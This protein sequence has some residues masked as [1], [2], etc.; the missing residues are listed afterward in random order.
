[1]FKFFTSDLRRNLI[2]ILCL[3][4]GLAVGFLLVAKIYFEQSYDSFFP[5]LDRIYRLTESVVQNGE[6]RE[7][8][9]T[10]GGSASELQRNISQIDKATR[11]TNLTGE[12]VM[13]LDD[14]RKFDVPCVTLADSCL[15]DVLKTPV[16]EGNPHEVLAVEDRLMI[17]RSLAE[18]IGGDV[19]GQRMS[20]VEWGDTYKATIGGVYEDYPLN[21]TIDNAVYI[22][23]PTIGK[24]M[25]DGSENLLGNDRYTSYVLL[26]EGADPEEVNRMMVEHLKTVI[27]EEEAFT[28]LDFRMWVR[29]MAGA[30]ARQDGVR[31][32][33]WMLGMLAL[34]ML[35]CAGLN[36]LLIV[37]G[38]LAARG[39][40]M[41]IRKCFGTG[42]KS[43][44][45]M[46]MGESLFFLIVSLGLAVLLAF[47]FS[48]LCKE[49][50][51]YSP[52]ELFSTGKVWLVEGLVCLGL[53]IITGIIPSIIYSRTPVAHAF[54]PAT[55]G[56]KIWKLALL[57]L[58]FLATGMIMC[59]LV[60]IGRQYHMIG[61][62]D[63]G[64]D[65]EDIGVFYRYP[66]TREKTYTVM[67][68]LR[69]L[70]FVESVASSDTDPTAWPSGNNLWTEGHQDDNEN[71]WDMEF[72]NPELFDVFGIEFVQGRN[73]S[74][75]PD[76]TVNEVIVDER[77]IEVLK[78]NF[79]ETD[80]YIVGKI[81]YMT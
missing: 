72:S 34:V 38:Q 24:F 10:P 28:I 35:M 57:A 31:T 55:C 77:M 13:K 51:G 39:K 67:K 76:S 71:I 56:R 65:Y 9:H 2:K 36:Y 64:V 14:G 42:R 70:P 16:L 19:I 75:N 15:F 30:Y 5:N 22:A 26:S 21:S 7:Y 78:T 11:F 12:A 48:D 3:T 74:E 81:V 53:L 68:E 43:I 40:E 17:P 47:C 52:K 25:H 20:I 59:L 27:D 66:M 61:N 50:L 46:V 18:K 41:A 54:R 4:V 73:F 49:L 79:G 44:F 8:Q 33:S 60:L 23:M 69:K 6:Y 45:F 80:E 58:Q 32:M 29:P 37:I 62:L 63:I 1:M